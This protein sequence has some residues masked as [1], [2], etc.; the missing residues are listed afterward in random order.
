VDPLD[1]KFIVIANPKLLVENEYK[2][3][4]DDF[5]KISFEEIIYFQ[6]SHKNIKQFS[7]GGKI[8]LIIYYLKIYLDFQTDVDISKKTSA[9]NLKKELVQYV[10]H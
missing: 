10:K 6:L 2:H 7:K 3:I 9:A 1:F 5:L 4:N 8:I